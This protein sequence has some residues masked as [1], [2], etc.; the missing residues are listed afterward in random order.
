MKTAIIIPTHEIGYYRNARTGRI[1]VVL[2]RGNKARHT[3]VAPTF[4]FAIFPQI[5]RKWAGDTVDATPEQLVA[6]DLMA[7]TKR[8]PVVQAPDR[9]LQVRYVIDPDGCRYIARLVG[10]PQEISVGAPWLRQVLGVS[11][12]AVLGSTP[13]TAA[14][15]MVLGFI[16]AKEVGADDSVQSVSLRAFA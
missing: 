2:G 5:N 4:F 6:L 15:A 8:E 10:T 11:D 3:S 1:D 16:V 13:V 7:A 14:Q 12:R 9:S